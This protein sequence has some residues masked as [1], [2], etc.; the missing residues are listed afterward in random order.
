MWAISDT[1]PF[2]DKDAHSACSLDAEQYADE[3][4]VRSWV[5]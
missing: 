2:S 4:W 3:Y 5:R 1:L